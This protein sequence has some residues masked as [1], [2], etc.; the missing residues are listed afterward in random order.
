[1]SACLDD[2]YL[3]ELGD[4]AVADYERRISQIPPEMCA[5]FTL[6]AMRLEYELILLY[7]LVVLCARSEQDLNKVASL[8]EFM[9][10]MCDAFAGR[11]KKLHDA[12]PSCGADSYYDKIL[13]LKNKCRRLQEMHQ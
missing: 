7:K 5:P 3:R 12:H 10:D 1:M 2:K 9:V 4:V 13:D 11:L 8:W 6:A